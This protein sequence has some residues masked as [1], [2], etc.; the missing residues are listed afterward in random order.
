MR[1]ILKLDNIVA[2]LQQNINLFFK[3][4]NI[5]KLKFAQT[6]KSVK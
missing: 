1:D 2:K 4:V 5:K 3:L 6:L